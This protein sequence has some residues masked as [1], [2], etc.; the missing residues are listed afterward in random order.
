[1][2]NFFDRSSQKERVTHKLILQNEVSQEN[3]HWEREISENPPPP[4][5]L[6]D[7]KCVCV[8]VLNWWDLYL[9]PDSANVTNIPRLP[10]ISDMNLCI[11][12]MNVFFFLF[13][14]LA[15]DRV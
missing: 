3:V 10:H 15:A 7:N 2:R 13:I 14:F 4:P 6:G 12:M 1:M 11:S 8:K 5:Q 9:S